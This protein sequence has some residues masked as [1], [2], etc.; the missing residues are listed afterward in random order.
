MGRINMFN[1]SVIILTSFVGVWT[2]VRFFEPIVV[3]KLREDGALRQ[4]MKFPKYD[5]NGDPILPEGVKQ[6]ESLMD[7]LTF[8]PNKADKDE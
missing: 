3:E 2:G 1:A 7:V 8:D 6:P 5:E 4:D